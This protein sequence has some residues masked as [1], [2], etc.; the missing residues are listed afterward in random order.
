MWRSDRELMSGATI[1]RSDANEPSLASN[2]GAISNLME[3]QPRLLIGEANA[4]SVS[5]I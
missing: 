1:E 3:M 4:S 5:S 2:A